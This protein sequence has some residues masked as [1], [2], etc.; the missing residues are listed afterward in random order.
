[1]YLILQKYYNNILLARYL[2]KLTQKFEGDPVKVE[3]IARFKAKFL[4][5]DF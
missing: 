4:L 2:Y 1:M 3:G 5:Q